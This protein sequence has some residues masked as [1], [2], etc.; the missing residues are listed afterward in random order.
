[1]EVDREL[2]GV[3]ED[4]IETSLERGNVYTSIWDTILGIILAYGESQMCGGRRNRKGLAAGWVLTL[5]R[6]V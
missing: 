3:V 5:A 4:R 1:M 2:V 6:W